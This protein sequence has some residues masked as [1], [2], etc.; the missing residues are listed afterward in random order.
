MNSLTRAGWGAGC[1]SCC[2][3]CRL[4]A[5]PLLTNLSLLRWAADCMCYKSLC[6]V[7]STLPA[8]DC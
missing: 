5:V 4:S 1:C 2:C 6:S 8:A 3:C 7:L